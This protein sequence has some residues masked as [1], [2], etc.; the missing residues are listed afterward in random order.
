MK[1]ESDWERLI[2]ERMPPRPRG[3]RVRHRLELAL[4]L[5]LQW[6]CNLLP[7]RALRRVGAGL[8]WVAYRIFGVRKT[9]ARDNIRRS[10]PECPDREVERIALGSYQNMGR[11]LMEYASF[12][13]L[14]RERVLDMV[15]V[16]GLA[17]FDAA[18]E[19]GRGA[20]LY[21]GH[22]GNWELL[23]AVIARCGY[24]VHCTDTIHTNPH[25]HRVINRLREAQGLKIISP[26]EPL[27]YLKTLLMNN[28]FV[29]YVADQDAGQGGIFV[30]FMG[31]PASTLRGP[32]ILSIRLDSPI[33]PGFL[34]RVGIDRHKAVCGKPLWPDKTLRGNAAI[35]DLTVRFTAVLEEFVRR[36]PDHYFWV[37]RRWKTKPP[38]EF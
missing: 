24:P 14:S 19:H 26:H 35:I 25:T 33:V 29:T 38:G 12:A 18:L 10:F 22:F 27:A 31:R 8:G 2:D 15:E 20:L 32:A 23:G 3:R 13:R 4:T 16:E 30:D 11:S 7:L 1:L 37:H 36:H 9:I 6:T 34:I 21:S 28:Q 17:N 5:A